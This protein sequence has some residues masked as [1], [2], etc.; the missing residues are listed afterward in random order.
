MSLA[1]S[2]YVRQFYKGNLFGATKN[3]RTGQT[4]NSLAMAD[5]KAIRK[6][7]REMGSF[8]Y[9][10][11]DGEELVKKVEAFVNTYN[12][13]VDSAKALGDEN[14]DRYLAQLK[15]MSK[16]FTDELDDIGISVQNSGK[17]AIDKKSLQSTG[18]YQVSKLFA[19]DAQFVTQVEKQIKRTQSMFVRND[20]DVA[21][22]AKKPQTEAAKPEDNPSEGGT[23][24]PEAAAARQNQQLVQQL[25][26]ALSGSQLNYTV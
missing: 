6:A 4:P 24:A 14:A 7:V 20:L 19:D 17:L 3:G 5:M 2:G 13:Y 23:D 8:D 22:P 18:R 25:A 21:K 9:D 26:Q 15:K 12:N 1:V 10:E 11:G 16:E